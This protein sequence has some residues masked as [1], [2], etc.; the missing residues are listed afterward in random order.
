MR[1]A[2]DDPLTPPSAGD[3]V[4]SPEA[5]ALRLLLRVM[6][7]T[8]PVAE[9][10]AGLRGLGASP[11]GLL[12]RMSAQGLG[13]RALPDALWREVLDGPSMA[14]LRSS[15]RMAAAWN[16]RLFDAQRSLDA[17]LSGAGRPY[18]YA[19]GLLLGWQLHGDLTTRASCD[20]DVM[21]RPDDADLFRAR[22]R[23]AGY[24]E[25]HPFP[26]A[27]PRYG[28][29]LNREAV[30]RS[31]PDGEA[32][33]HVELQWSPVLPF[34]R[35]RVDPA[36]LLEGG[37][38]LRLAGVDWPVPSDEAQLTVLLLHHGVTDG[39]RSLRHVLDL[40][41]FLRRLGGGVDWQR[42]R[43]GLRAMGLYAHAAAGFSLCQALTGV[44]AP[45]GFAVAPGVM[46]RLE[47]TLLTARQLTRDQRSWPFL[48][49][50]WL[51]A[52]GT[53]GRARLVVGQLQKALSPGL[54]EL[55]LLAL[56]ARWFPVYYLLKP[57]RPLWRPFRRAGADG[58]YP[59][60][61]GPLHEAPPPVRTL[62]AD[63]H[64]P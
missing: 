64:P 57:L 5:L 58:G 55:G 11:E 38:H 12:R 48:R 39:W 1:T 56:P 60:K 61:A 14:R 54:D 29:W 42:Y 24:E 19:K 8:L 35:M 41:V 47:A 36:A 53:R 31:R 33:V 21:V 25:V 43:E 17:L 50:Q 7:G 23:S 44:P 28:R 52:G 46:G 3:G 2:G 51:L 34:Y 45:P 10:A 15:D 59:E 9:A 32:P 30:F 63:S 4:R 26:E 37:R 40:A 13:G 18:R 27:H 16:L 49:R 62:Q 6:A 22:L 20:I